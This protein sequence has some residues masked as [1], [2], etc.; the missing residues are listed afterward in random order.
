MF[1]KKLNFRNYNEI[2]R[3][4]LRNKLE[5]PPYRYW[6]KLWNNNEKKVGEGIIS[7]NKLVGYHSF[8]KK[9][10]RL[11]NKFYNI[12]ISSNWNVDKNF[13]NTS[14]ILLNRYF[15]A[16]CDFFITT[17]AN[18]IVS[19]IW[20]SFGA[21]EVNSIGCTKVIFKVLDISKFIKAF[22]IKKKINLP[23][24]IISMISFFFRIYIFIFKNNKID[25]T[26]EYF[27]VKF[28]LSKI[29]QF[30]KHYEK[31]SNT[32]HE[33]RSNDNLKDYLEAISY[34]KKIHIIIFKENNLMIGYAILVSEKLYKTKI[35]RMN[36]GQIR[37]LNQ[38]YKYINEIF[39]YLSI[40]SKNKGCAFIEFR[41]LNKNILNK[42]KFNNFFSR[43]LE[44]N[45]YLIKF[46]DNEY[47]EIKKFVKNNWDTS[48]LDGDCLL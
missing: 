13:R 3:L 22:L 27:P 15:K 48:Y 40:F 11:K 29:N 28:N 26:L 9:K 42:L 46:K 41:N 47:D 25:K 35:K 37:L 14:I 38:K 16:N 19:K 18:K 5:I 7:K 36:L 6:K 32:P 2:R 44:N 17:T 24:I 45:P 1:I 12:L 33:V 43:L 34:N 30:N 23:N 20:K 31:Y 4:I 39:D 10:I 8:F 21:I